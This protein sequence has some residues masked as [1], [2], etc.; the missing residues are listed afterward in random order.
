M[1][2]VLIIT[3]YWPPSGGAGVQRWLKFSK[4]L[5]GSGWEPVIL[6]VDPQWAVYPQQDHSLSEEISPSLEIIKTKSS[7]GFFSVYKLLTGRK[8]IPYGGFAN[9]DNPDPAQKFS[10]FIRGN[11]VLPDARKGWNRFAFRAALKIIKEKKI[12][13]VI[14][15]SPPH[16]TQL[17][18]LK[19]KR[20]L[21]IKWI[22]DLRDPWTD[23]YYSDSMYQTCFARKINSSMEKKVLNNADNIITTCNATGKLFRSKLDKTQP[24]GKISTIT[25]G[26]DPADFNFST[27]RPE[28][29]TIT[30][31]G[32]FAGNYDAEVLAEA[33]DYFGAHNSTIIN[34]NFIG[35][36]DSKI[37]K[38][39]RYKKNVN[40]GLIPYVEHKKAMEYLAISVALLL[41]VPSGKNV[42]EPIPGKLFEYL[43]SKRKIIAL[44][45]KDGDVAEI[46]EKTNG[47]RVFGEDDSGQLAK[48]LLN[49]D[50]DFLNG[51]YESNPEGLEK[52]TRQNLAVNIAG[53]LNSL[54]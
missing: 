33:F 49:I 3:Y 7:T 52:F 8:E 4:Y 30:Y 46:L 54:K 44:A 37:E 15:T 42:N 18:G 20:S 41:V 29:F 48:Y 39:F 17:I 35:K 28:S 51:I 9:E 45:P 31:L 16:S 1:N 13:Y 25:N 50:K 2:K 26:Y 19:L 11:F 21:N 23:I 14:T 6:T 40:L 10:R 27:L 47:G 32:T 43:A 24:A 5:P 34:L 36:T 12:D 22:A 53:I 38:I